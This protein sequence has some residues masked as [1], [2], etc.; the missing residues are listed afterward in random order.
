M[1]I[2]PE[3]Q[4]ETRFNKTNLCHVYIGDRIVHRREIGR[5]L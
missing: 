1:Q 2:T 4:K 3:H 5:H